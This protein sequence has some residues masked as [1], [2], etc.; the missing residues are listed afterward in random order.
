MQTIKPVSAWAEERH[1]Y[2]LIAAISKGFKCRWP[3]Y[4]EKELVS[5]DVPEEG[6]LFS[7]QDRD[8]ISTLAV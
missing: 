1:V 8:K 5:L 3:Y 4:G 2:D 6:E 7:E